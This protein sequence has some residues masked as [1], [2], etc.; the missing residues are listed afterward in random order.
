MEPTPRPDLNCPCGLMVIEHDAEP[1]Y[2]CHGCFLA[3]Q[4]CTCPKAGELI[5]PDLEDPK[6]IV[7]EVS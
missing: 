6:P 4:A 5:I 3:P 7:Q 2:R 1:Y